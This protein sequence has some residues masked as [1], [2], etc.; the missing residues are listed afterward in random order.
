MGFTMAYLQKRFEEMLIF[1]YID[2]HM[3]LTDITGMYYI[4]QI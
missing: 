2:I 4:N 3:G 1:Q